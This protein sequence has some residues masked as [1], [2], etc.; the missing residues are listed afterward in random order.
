VNMV[1]GNVVR[2]H[3]PGLVTLP[4]SESILATT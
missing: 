1:L 4:S 3:W 2:L